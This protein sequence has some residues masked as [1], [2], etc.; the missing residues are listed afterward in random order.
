VFWRGFF[1]DPAFLAGLANICK[2]IRTW[3][4]ELNVGPSDVIDPVSGWYYQSRN[5][6][7][8]SRAVFPAPGKTLPTT[9]EIT[10]FL[11][12]AILQEVVSR[13]F[14]TPAKG[15]TVIPENVLP[16]RAYEEQ[17]WHFD[18]VYEQA[19]I[20]VLADEV[21]ERNGPM[22]IIP[23]TH[24]FSGQRRL[25]EF[26]Y[27][28]EGADFSDVPI[29]LVKKHREAVELC[30]GKPGDV[31][32]FNTSAFHATGRADDGERLTATLYFLKLSTPRNKF[33]DSVH[34]GY[35]I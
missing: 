14:K 4:D 17:W 34:P 10:A 2:T 26:N 24:Q 9:P 35:H 33:L 23:G 13:A 30:T 25:L 19:K 29:S 6:S 27:F 22:K 18:R 3:S 11:Q 32:F 21:T 20:M 7:G 12:N 1:T 8:R 15:E 28:S 31:V 5:D 16:T